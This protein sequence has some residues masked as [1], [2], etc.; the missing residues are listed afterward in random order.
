MDFN[1][2]LQI[3]SPNQEEVHHATETIMKAAENPSFIQVLFQLLQSQES[4]SNPTLEKMIHLTILQLIRT[5]WTSH[6][7]P[8]NETIYWNPHQQNEIADHLL[9]LLLSLDPSKRDNIIE[10]FR[11][12]MIISFPMNIEMAEKVVNLFDANAA[13]LENVV[14]ILQIFTFWSKA[15]ANYSISNTPPEI[16]QKVEEIAL[17]MINRLSTFS[18]QT[19]SFALLRFAA[20][21]L[22]NFTKKLSGPLLC[23]NFDKILSLLVNSLVVNDKS[24]RELHLLKRSTL[25]L[26]IGLCSTFFP[27]TNEEHSQDNSSQIRLNYGLHFKQDIAPC[28]LQSL[29]QC[30]SFER[31]SY[32]LSSIMYLFYQF[33]FYKVGNGSF[34]TT[35]FVTNIIIPI[36]RLSPEDVNESVINPLQFLAFNFSYET[37]PGI[38]TTRSTTASLIGVI[39]KEERF[40]DDLYDYLLAPT[41]NQ[42]D[43]EGRIF[44]MTKFVM[45]TMTNMGPMITG[46]VVDALAEQTK[47]VDKLPPFLSTSLLMFMSSVLPFLDPELGCRL[48]SDCIIGSDHQ[49]VI[50]AASKLLRASI[51]ECD[52]RVD[53]PIP[54]IIPKLLNLA[55]IVKYKYLTMAVEALIQMGGSAIYPFVKDTISG[56]FE[57][58]N[59]SLAEG[60]SKDCSSTLY[61]I[62]EIINAIPDDAPILVE[63]SELILP[64]CIQMFHQYPDNHSFNDIFLLISVFNT[65]IDNVTETMINTYI[66]T[67]QIIRKDDVL[68]QNSMDSIS[69]LMCPIIANQ[70]F[71]GNSQLI[72]ATVDILMHFIQVCMKD[73]DK[74]GLAYTILIVATLIQSIGDSGLAFI[75]HICQ[76]LNGVDDKSATC[77]F[78]ACVFAFSSALMANSEKAFPMIPGNVIEFILPRINENTLQTY[79]EL[80]MGFYFLLRATQSG[81]A[82]A[83]PAAV[84]ILRPLCER[85]IENNMKMEEKMQTANEL[86]QKQIEAE[87]PPLVIPFNLPSDTVDEYNL[88]G[89]ITQ[90]SGLFQQ[91]SPVQQQIVREIFQ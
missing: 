81:I 84:N 56:L 86:M 57:L 47:H 80:K 74:D 3:C 62:F 39:L 58:A 24:N 48:A 35:E 71:K 65:K 82:A 44:L 46:D 7:E 43:F 13:S 41:V 45:A 52:Q 29:I 66:Q 33:L 76:A 42:I 53:L 59:Q 49:I 88:F 54:S 9:N 75:P 31:D 1:I 23:E 85:K 22:K 38:R 12:I 73:E 30:I 79:K 61:S 32:I 50:C 6:I 28:L 37:S 4:Q 77:L 60:V 34:L 64:A 25:N 72:A 27:L 17:A 63:L 15:C 51:I 2:F 68:L 16:S 18:L 26:F 14:S 90:S 40:I 5:H 21:S 20:K 67:L 91:L 8:E 89:Q 19:Q 69:F 83:Y 70:G 55:S 10:C 11:Y 87:F 36:A 78:S